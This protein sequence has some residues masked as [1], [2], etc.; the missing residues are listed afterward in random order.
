MIAVMNIQYFLFFFVIVFLFSGAGINNSFAQAELT[1]WGNLRGI[2]VEGQL[3][4]FTTSMCLIGPSMADVTGSA[5]EKQQPIYTRNDN[6]QFVTTELSKFAF[7]EMVQDTGNARVKI[8]IKVKAVVDTLLT[9]AFLC[10][11]LPE[12]EYSGAT[13]Q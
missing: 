2:R 5:K 13:I 7:T 6:K 9:G 10:F 4:K 3:M 12:D 1:A 8:N 11:D